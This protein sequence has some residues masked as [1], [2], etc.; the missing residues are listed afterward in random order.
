MDAVG[1]F[2]GRKDGTVEGLALVVDVDDG[3]F[4]KLVSVGEVIGSSFGE[5]SSFSFASFSLT[6][7]SFTTTSTDFNT[8]SLA[9]MDEEL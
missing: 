6:E 8:W 7:R 3:V 1:C 2:L 9:F 5:V 4:S